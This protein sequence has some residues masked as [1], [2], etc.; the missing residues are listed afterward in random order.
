MARTEALRVSRS[1]PRCG[2]PIVLRRRKSDGR[3]FVSCSG[4][5]L[6]RFAEDYSVHER[7]LAGR[8]EALEHEVTVLGARLAAVESS[9]R[10]RTEEDVVYV[11][12]ALADRVKALVVR[13]HPD[14]HGGAALATEVC[15]ALN[16]LRYKVAGKGRGAF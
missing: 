11:R 16:D 6:C 10:L 3:H 15:A 1:C 8:I 2:D 14:R 5:P 4:F 13:F 7:R 9:R 12:D